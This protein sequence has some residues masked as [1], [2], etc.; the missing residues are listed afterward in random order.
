VICEFQVQHDEDKPLPY[1]GVGYVVR[2]EDSRAAIDF[3]AGGFLP[4]K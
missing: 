2:V 4:L 3:K 1:W